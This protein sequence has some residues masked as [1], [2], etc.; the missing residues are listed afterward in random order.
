MAAEQLLTFEDIYTAICNEVKIPLTDEETVTR[1][2]RDI[3]MIYI[4]EIVPFKQRKWDWLSGNKTIA[5]PVVYVTGTVTVTN[6]DA[7]ITFSDLP[8][9][10]I[11]GFILKIDGRPE[12]FN[13]LSHDFGDT[14][15]VELEVDWPFDTATVGFKL[16]KDTLTLPS[17][18]NEVIA[19]THNRRATPMDIV[20]AAKF[21]ET[22]SRFPDIQ[23]PPEICT[24][25]ALTFKYFPAC[26]T[27]S[28]ILNIEGRLKATALDGDN[29]APLIPI[30][31]RIVLFYGAC[32]RAWSRERN[33][34]EANRN[35]NLF[36]RKL[37]QMVARSPGA[38]DTTEMSV[39]A[40]YLRDKR[41]RR[42][43]K[44]NAR[45]FRVD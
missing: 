41:Y 31:D 27:E 10:D 8:S 30:E 21:N 32:S 13:I 23:R 7:T 2:K 4:N 35:W 45:G 22:K 16:W 18:F 9:E 34:G 42:W 19:V 20:N 40:N 24:V 17:T 36:M 1:I 33:E 28:Y 43:N 37:N 39:D 44:R 26:N 38:S 12:V 3:N 14:E 25:N 11:T 15:A 29:D 5:T 6:G